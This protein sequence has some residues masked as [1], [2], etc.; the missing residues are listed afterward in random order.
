MRAFSYRQP[1]QLS[2]LLALIG[3][4]G[5]QTR[6]LAGGQS[7]NMALK[8]RSA[9]PSRVVSVRGL[10]DL[11]I[12]RYADDGTLHVGAATTYAEL[13]AAE[14]RGWHTELSAVAGNLADR[15]VRNI[16]TIGGAA[17]QAEPRYDVP[18]LLVGVGA[19]LR[20][21]CAGGERL[22][23]ARGFFQAAGGTCLQPHELLTT[24]LF[25]P[26]SP[27]VQVALEK[28]RYRSFEAAILIVLCALSLDAAGVALSARLT[29]GAVA[30]APL[31][32]PLAAASIIG[33]RRSEITMADLADRIASEIL[34]PERQTNRQLQYQAELVKT[35]AI[36]AVE[37]AFGQSGGVAAHV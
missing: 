21:V 14:L 9:A 5:Q 34:P 12:V 19:T 28:F 24:I 26:A 4:P 15:S 8:D 18:T 1:R 16:A 11:R 33:R 22:V 27:D 29:V 30:K 17:C 7:L 2:E 32:A 31:L 35:L 25:P 3:E 37:R 10:P 36:R 23:P 20:L 6:L 13:A